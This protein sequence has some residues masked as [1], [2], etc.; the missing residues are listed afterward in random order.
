MYVSDIAKGMRQDGHRVAVMSV[1]VEG[2]D[3]HPDVYR[4]AE[5][6]HATLDRLVD[7]VVGRVSPSLARS[8]SWCR[9]IAAATNRAVAERGLQLLEMEEA[10]G[11]PALVWPR[12][13]VPIVVRLHG[14]WFING[15][16]QGAREDAE[17]RQRVQWERKAIVEAEALTAPSRDVLDR[18]RAYYEIPLESAVVI[19]N[20]GPVVPPEHRWRAADCDPSRVLFVGRFDLHKGG[21]VMIDAFVALL[22]DRPDARLSLAGPDFGLTD[23]DGR[24][25]DIRSYLSDRAGRDWAEGRIEWLGPQPHSALEQLRKQAAVTVVASRYDNFPTTVLEAMSYGS[26]LVA[27]RIGGIPEM[28]EDGVH[29]L[30]CPPGDAPELAAAIRRLLDDPALAAR[31]GAQAAAHCHRTY[32]PTT[33]ARAMADYYRSV[34]DR[35]RLRPPRGR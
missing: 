15:P 33:V 34:L 28:V 9:S 4:L 20:P 24:R 25:W 23:G 30:L 22:R 14:P 27:T 31:L 3:R 19:P 6:R 18:T 8:R 13:S 17:F 32:H 29:G 35:A 11:W 10:L 1:R 21:D 26:P 7:K 2:E 5:V 12:I 16:L